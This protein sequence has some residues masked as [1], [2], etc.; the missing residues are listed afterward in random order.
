MTEPLP[1]A[2]RVAKDIRDLLIIGALTPGQRLSETAFSERLDVSRNSLR[3]AFRLLTK[4]GLLRHEANRGVFVSVPSTEQIIDIYRVRR[5]LECAALR[6]AWPKHSAVGI[7]RAA[8]EHAKMRRDE[9]DWREVGSANMR[10]HAAVVDLSDSSRLSDFYARVAAELRLSFGLLNDPEQLH[11]PFVDMNDQIL[12]L[13]E[14]GEVVE[15]A[16]QME[17]YLNLSE[18]TVLKALER[19]AK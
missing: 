9:G 14:K 6:Q 15:A 10:F 18:R 13:V 17:H 19:A 5:M 1:L 7:M 3:E 11:S 8:V 4:D 2:D 12:S 16:V